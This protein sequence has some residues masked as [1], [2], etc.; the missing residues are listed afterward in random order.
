LRQRF[1]AGCNIVRA[2]CGLAL[3][4]LLLA[5]STAAEDNPPL[6]PRDEIFA[7]KILMDSIDE[8][9]DAIDWMLSAGGTIDLARA[10]EHADTISVMLMAFPH[11]FPPA[12]NQW[13]PNAKR[14]P[15]R[16][17]FAAPELWTNFADFYR[18]AAAASR[19][20]FAASRS[21]RRDDFETQVEA[22]RSAC[23]T[24]HARYMKSGD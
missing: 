17:T 10:S 4:A 18:Q 11:L 15:A 14:D 6:I 21:K 22:L 12:T 1:A 9:L 3:A 5:S 8:H 2:L 13:Q 20:A 7:R 16:D 24:C 19:L 23:A